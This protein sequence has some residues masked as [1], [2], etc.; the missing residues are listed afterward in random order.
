MNRE[1]MIDAKT[2]KRMLL[3]GARNLYDNVKEVNDLN[4]F[5]IPDG[6]TGENMYLTIKGGADEIFSRDD[7]SVGELSE[8]F[9]KGMLLNARGN[10]GVILSQLFFG[11]SEG[12]KGFEEVGLIDFSHALE[13]GVKRAYSAVAKPVEGTILTVAR[14]SVEN[15]R[16]LIETDTSIEDFLRKMLEEMK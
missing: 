13:Q 10:S 14:E 3:F 7:L 9:A 6:D 4:V 2:F 12:L 5:P 1:K 8:K 16:N 11:L 15:V